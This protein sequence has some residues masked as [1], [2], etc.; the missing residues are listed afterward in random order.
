VRQSRPLL[1]T[2][3]GW[4]TILLG[5]LEIAGGVLLLVFRD[6]AL[7]ETSFTGDELTAITIVVFVVG[8]IYVLVGRGMLRLNAFALGLG[9]VVSALALGANLIYLFSV[10]ADHSGLVGNLVVNLIVL[11]ACV[12][13]FRARPG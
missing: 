3:V 1:L 8:L 9:L 2:I 6:N 12:S 7:D 13:G 11:F 10:D 4:I 5:L